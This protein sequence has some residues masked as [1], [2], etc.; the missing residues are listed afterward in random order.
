LRIDRTHRSWFVGSVVTLGVATAIYVPYAL[1]I[2]GPSGRSALGLIYGSI[3]FG[4]MIF[5]GLLGLRKKFP[6][7]R[8]GRAQTWMRAHLW[9]GFLSYPLILLHGAFHFG[10]PLTRVMMWIFTVVFVSGIVGAAIQHFMPRVHTSQLPMETIYEQ[11]DHVRDQLAMEAGRLVDS[12]CDALDGELSR[13]SV[14]QLA[15]AASAGTD[16]DVTVADGL[17]F[18]EQASRQLRD[19]F[20]DETLPYLE[21]AGSRGTTL[22]DPLRA[23]GTF[24]QLRIVLPA[25]LHST[26]GDLETICDEKR[27]LDQ[28]RKYHLVL[29]GWLLVH[30]PLS[31]AVLL[32]GA[33]HAVIALKY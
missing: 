28:Q 23:K 19:F 27:Q 17:G 11:I 12:A 1:Q 29:H 13:A 18:N 20:L 31:Y 14:G 26:V 4:F 22:A 25:S 33:V 2:P 8:I 6:V 7:W 10:G 5:A 15:A 24:Q 9:L 3:G 21:K 32:L 30:I 16:W